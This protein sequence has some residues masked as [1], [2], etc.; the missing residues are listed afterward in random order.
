M[1][2]EFHRFYD[3]VI[4]EGLLDLSS[5]VASRF[6]AITDNFLRLSG[7][8]AGETGYISPEDDRTTITH[9][10]QGPTDSSSASALSPRKSL[11]DGSIRS[12]GSASK[13]LSHGKEIVA[14]AMT[15]YEIVAQATPDNASFPLYTSMDVAP[16]LAPFASIGS[17]YAT[18]PLSRSLAYHELTFGRR[19]ERRTTERGFYLATVENPPPERYAEVFGFCL[20]FD[21]RATIADQLNLQLSN[22]VMPLQDQVNPQRGPWD[23]KMEQRVRLTFGFEKE[24]MNSDEIEQ[25]LRQCGII[26]SRQAEFVDAEVDV[27]ELSDVPSNLLLQGGSV[28]YPSQAS[29]YDSQDTPVGLSVPL[30]MTGNSGNSL[31][32]LQAPG[33]ASNN[34][35]LPY[36][37]SAGM[38][39]MWGST[40]A[41]PKLTLS[42]SV[43]VEGKLLLVWRDTVANILTIWFF[44]F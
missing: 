2:R 24:F 16:N 35:M 14:G 38:D 3:L 25:Y 41:K 19:L 33:G 43:L 27:N 10:L 30:E 39:N 34:G 8:S 12:S 26:I 17:P 9:G 40:W 44:F 4:S 6:R 18:L 28:S 7:L 20:L 13:N 1:T 11:P 23:E 21:T 15:S 42:V 29:T 36:M 5:E 32:Q 31:M 22:L 37:F